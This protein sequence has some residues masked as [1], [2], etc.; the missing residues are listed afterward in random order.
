MSNNQRVYSDEE[1]ALVLRK[2]A[3][4]A[5]R[6]ESPTSFAAGLTLTEM[7]A[8]A[9]QVG[10]DPTLVERAAR[11]LDTGATASP[12]ERMMGGPLRHDNEARFPIKLDENRAALL[13]S[14]VRI[15]VGHAGS[16][17]AGH[18][19]SIGMTWHDGGEVEALGVTASPEADGTAV[20][21]T[22]DRRGTFAVVAMVSGLSMFFTVLFGAF[23]LYPEAPALG[24]GGSVAGI[25][26]TL[27]VARGYWASSTRKVRERI[28]VVMDTIG[29]TISQPDT[30]EPGF[31]AVG[32][33]AAAAEADTS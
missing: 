12:L 20:S 2:A 7:K 28:S 16:R 11:L 15:R 3:E 31:G 25:G 1:F 23:A 33:A 9:A 14:T 29:Q 22:L 5:S 27:A 6:A 19:S 18:S 21:V 4:L 24:I 26:G 8:A 32:D 17:D 10:I 13:L 30:Q